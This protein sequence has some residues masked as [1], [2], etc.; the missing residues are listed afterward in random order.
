MKNNKEWPK[1]LV[2]I[3]FSRKK[4]EFHTIE[5]VSVGFNDM[6]V[7]FHSG[8]LTGKGISRVHQF[9]GEKAYAEAMKLAYQ[10]LRKKKEEGFIEKEYMIEGINYAIDLDKKENGKKEKKKEKKAN[11][12]KEKKHCD[13]CQKEIEW[14]LYKKIVEWARNEGNW[15]YHENSPL[16][17]KIACIECQQDKGIF[18]KRLDEDTNL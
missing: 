7:I 4:F 11:L 3:D 17:N 13:F 18:Q 1:E 5:I 9:K 16:F 2:L 14:K 8:K 15:D 6:Q 10:R 12:K